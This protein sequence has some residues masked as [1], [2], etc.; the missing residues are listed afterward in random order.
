MR[1]LHRLAALVAGVA[2]MCV[3][4][5]ARA[6]SAEKIPL[7]ILYMG[8]PESAR[9]KD[10][11]QFLQDH[12]A[13]VAVMDAAKFDP[14]QTA[15]Y[16]VVILDYDPASKDVTKLAKQIKLPANYSKP[17]VLEGFLGARVGSALGLRLGFS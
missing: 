11:A 4:G 3:S 13:K 2:V 12:F 7:N 17:T 10:F 15:A 6:E 5:L 8:Q 16:D 9:A 1:S 14:A